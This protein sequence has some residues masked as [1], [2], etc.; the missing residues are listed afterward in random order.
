M[1]TCPYCGEDFNHVQS[2]VTVYDP[3]GDET[4]PFYRGTKRAIKRKTGFR[5]SALQIEFYCETCPRFWFLIL[6]QHKG[7]TF[8]INCRGRKPTKKELEADSWATIL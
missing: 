1:V 8:M 7:T 6:Q 5:R 3:E 4:I 2:V